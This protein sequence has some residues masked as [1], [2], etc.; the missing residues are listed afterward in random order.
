MLDES[1]LR[2]R[3]ISAQLWSIPWCRGECEP[4]ELVRAVSVC[5]FVLQGSS[6]TNV[7]DFL[8]LILDGYSPYRRL[9][10][11]FEYE[12]HVNIVM[13]VRSLMPLAPLPRCFK[14]SSQHD[15]LSGFDRNLEIW[16]NSLSEICNC[17]GLTVVVPEIEIARSSLA[18][19]EQLVTRALPLILFRKC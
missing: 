5:A 12:L 8:E 17:F 3:E 15:H 14:S 2:L 13:S 16:T 6:G 10:S 18:R 4:V 19:R 9:I 1:S 7:R 11:Y